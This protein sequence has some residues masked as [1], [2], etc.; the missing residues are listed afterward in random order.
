MQLS[1]RSLIP[2]RAAVCFVILFL[3]ISAGPAA[4]QNGAKDPAGALTQLSLEEL[5]N[6]DVTITSTSRKPQKAFETPSAA[7]VLTGEDIRRSGVTTIPD[8]LRMVPGMSVA[9][10]NTNK[11]AITSRG[12]NGRFASK[13]LVLVDGRTVYSPL[14]SGVYWDTQDMLLDD[15]D[16]IEVIRGP[17]SSLWGANA[18]N[19]IIN[20]ITKHSAAT[21]GS[22][23]TAAVGSKDHGSFGVRYGG[24]LSQGS[25]YRAYAKYFNDEESADADGTASGDYW[26]AVR[27]G[28]RADSNLSNRDSLSFQADIYKGEAGEPLAL[29]S[30]TA[31]YVQNVIDRATMKGFNAVGRWQRR[32]SARS[33]FQLQAYYDHSVREN[34]RLSE[35]LHTFDVDF[36]RR[37]IWRDNHEILWGLGFRITHD[38]IGDSFFFSFDP[39][40]RTDKLYSGFVQD[41]ISLVKNKLVFTVGTKFEHNDYTGAELEPSANLAWMPNKKNTFWTSISRAIRTPDRIESDSRHNPTVIPGSMPSVLRILGNHTIDHEDVLA[42]EAGYRTQP[43]NRVYFDVGLF[44]N[45]YDQLRTFEPETPFVETSPSPTH[46][47]IPLRMDNLMSGRTYGVEIAIDLKLT[48]WWQLKT[49]YSYLHMNLIPDANSKDTRSKAEEGQNPANQLSFQ[50]IMDFRRRFEFDIST[51]YVSEMPVLS[52]DGYVE[53]DARFGY[54][55]SD[56]WEFSI[57]G[58]NLLNK[59]HREWGADRD[60]HDPSEVPR[61]A[62]GKLALRF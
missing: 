58:Q 4:A 37:F 2:V 51:R 1:S 46:R 25:Y 6:L 43:H 10:I 45:F 57:V 31:P 18:V 48:G 27:A 55:I 5:M 36:Q 26:K 11:W 47:V 41:S 49:G 60:N 42:L 54:Q 16:R 29:P 8:A 24:S 32:Y 9:R 15:V 35:G 19:G 30:L 53:L 20:I 13:L 59:Q 17:G 39:A 52:V 21:T 44:Y 34:V 7:Y 33:D 61:M 22:L 38:S 40:R 12:F 14:F 50:S 28:F 3:G 62:Y 56:H 23:A